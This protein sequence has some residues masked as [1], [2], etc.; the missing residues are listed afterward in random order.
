MIDVKTLPLKFKDISDS[1]PVGYSLSNRV[2][3][4]EILIDRKKNR[5]EA[6]IRPTLCNYFVSVCNFQVTEQDPNNWSWGSD[7]PPTPTKN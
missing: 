1:L 7:G 2:L 6:N 4:A 3:D 5:I